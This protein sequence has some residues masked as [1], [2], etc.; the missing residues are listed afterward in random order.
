MAAPADIT[1]KDLSGQWVMNRTISEDPDQ[2]LAL[3]GVSWF[4]RKAVGLATITLQINQYTGDSSVTQID[5]D[6]ILTGG[7]KGT[8]EKRALN[9]EWRDHK[10]GIFGEVKGKSRWVKLAELEEEFLREGWLV[11]GESEEFIQSYVE[12][13][14]NGWTADQVWGFAEIQGKRYYTRRLVVKKGDETIKAVMAYD[15]LKK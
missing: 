13:V 11:E 15:F 12:S 3:Q 1:L 9:W 14:G 8:T 10:D 6:Q 5:I 2:I 7:L 4:I